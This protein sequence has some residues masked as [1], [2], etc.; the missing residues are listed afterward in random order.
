MKFL[1]L[2]A[3]SAT[4]ASVAAAPAGLPR[5][6]R[7]GWGTL[8]VQQYCPEGSLGTFP[9]TFQDTSNPDPDR[10]WSIQSEYSEY[11]V[12]GAVKY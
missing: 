11:N 1:A 8:R 9:K 5:L 2:V 4:V 10:I 6:P 7:L 3:F 12:S